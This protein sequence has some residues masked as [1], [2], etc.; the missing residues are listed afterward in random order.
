MALKNNL[1]LWQVQ[2]HLVTCRVSSIGGKG[3]RWT[4]IG[5]NLPSTCP[6]VNKTQA[7]KNFCIDVEDSTFIIYET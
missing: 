7:I 1:L 6:K 3:G 4:A 2:A 5:A